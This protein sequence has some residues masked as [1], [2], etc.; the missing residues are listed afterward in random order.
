MRSIL[1]LL[2]SFGSA[3]ALR[4]ARA[5][6][7]LTHTRRVQAALLERRVGTIDA[8]AA[9]QDIAG[10]GRPVAFPAAA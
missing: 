4:N 3:G 6:L 9:R 2:Q 5:E 10:P 8:V 1:S 7:E